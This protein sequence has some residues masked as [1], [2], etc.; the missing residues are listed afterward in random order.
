MFKVKYT[1]QYLH[2]FYV[3][4]IYILDSSIVYINILK[5]IESLLQEEGVN[6]N[7]NACLEKRI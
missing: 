2:I 3:N 7:D 6:F 5:S 4:H 1:L